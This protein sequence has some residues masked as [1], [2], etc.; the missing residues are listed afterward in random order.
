M[1]NHEKLAQICVPSAAIASIG[2]NDVSFQNAMRKI[3]LPHLYSWNRRTHKRCTTG[4]RLHLLKSPKIIGLLSIPRK[5]VENSENNCAEIEGAILM[6]CQLC[7]V[8][9]NAKMFQ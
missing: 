1:K 6:Q 3:V 2:S 5:F 8:A 7:N 4:G 9:G